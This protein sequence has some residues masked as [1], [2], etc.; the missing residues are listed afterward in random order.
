MALFE[1]YNV[2]QKLNFLTHP[3]KLLEF[4]KKFS[5]LSKYK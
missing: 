3:D 1:T 4:I 5:K 2:K